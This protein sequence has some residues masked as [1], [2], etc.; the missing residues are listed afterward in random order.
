M[1]DVH[2]CYQATPHSCS[3]VLFS[4]LLGIVITEEHYRFLQVLTDR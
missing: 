1:S 3:L 2:E 4:D